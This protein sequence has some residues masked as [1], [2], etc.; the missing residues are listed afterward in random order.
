MNVK[1][2]LCPVDFTRPSEQAI[3]RASALARQ[4]GSKL[5][6]IH[7]YEPVFADGY[8]DGMPMTVP[9]AD[10]DPRRTQL[11]SV[12]PTGDG[13]L[14][15]CHELIVGFPAGSIVGYAAAKDID[16]IVI[17]THGRTGVSR[18][19][20]GSVAE[21]VVRAANCPVLTVHDVDAAE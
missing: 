14:E 2:I 17:G 6:F 8:V 3:E 1:H 13:D 12:Q 4:F 18:W 16:L 9:P 19:L 7:V 10:L 11:E 21:A 15:C 5:H 20:L